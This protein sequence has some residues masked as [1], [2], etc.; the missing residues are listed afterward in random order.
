MLIVEY[1]LMKLIPG[2]GR[3]SPLPPENR[4]SETTTRIMCIATDSE[5]NA[6]Q[7]EIHA[8][9]I[10]ICILFVRIIL[11]K[12]NNYTKTKSYNINRYG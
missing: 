2:F 7:C 9:A 8:K 4:F 1:L 3:F 11:I 10:G 5:G 6:A 12:L